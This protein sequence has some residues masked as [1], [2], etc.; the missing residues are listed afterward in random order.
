MKNI[1]VTAVVFLVSLVKPAL[2]ESNETV[3]STG[4]ALKACTAKEVA[5]IDFCNGFVQAS[6]DFAVINKVACPPRG[7]QRRYLSKLFREKALL[8]NQSQPAIIIFS[9]ILSRKYPCN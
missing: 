6:S 5:W 8:Y 7:V 4:D 3:F 2:G 1:F 9:M